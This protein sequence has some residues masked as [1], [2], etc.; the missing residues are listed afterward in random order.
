[1]NIFCDLSRSQQPTSTWL[2]ALDTNIIEDAVV[3]T[4]VVANYTQPRLAVMEDIAILLYK[5]TFWI[6][7]F[8]SAK[9]EF[10]YKQLS[11]T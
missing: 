4:I 7:H 11:S 5:K 9:F 10:V 1:M 6:R 2:A 3:L 8:L